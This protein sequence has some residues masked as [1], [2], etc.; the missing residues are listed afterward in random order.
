MARAFDVSEV[1]GEVRSCARVRRALRVG[2]MFWRGNREP[3]V[4]SRV[5]FLQRRHV[6]SPS[7]AVI[8]SSIS[9]TSGSGS[10][11]GSGSLEVGRVCHGIGGGPFREILEFGL[12][13]HPAVSRSKYTESLQK[14][15]TT[16]ILFYL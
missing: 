16:E 2:L 10:G 6:G 14:R 4:S 11:S 8:S 5:K 1:K 3:W 15:L 12:G 9:S 13:E 7:S